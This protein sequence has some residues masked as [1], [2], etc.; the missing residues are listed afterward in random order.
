MTSIKNIKCTT[1]G[2]PLKV[3]ESE[4][5]QKCDHC[6]SEYVTVQEEDGTA[7]QLNQLSPSLDRAASEMAI[8]RLKEELLELDAQAIIKLEE[9]EN[10]KKQSISEI[11]KR[12]KEQLSSDAFAKLKNELDILQ[13]ERDNAEV[14]GK[15]RFGY[16]TALNTS[17]GLTGGCVTLIL[18]FISLTIL[19][20]FIIAFL[21]AFAN[22]VISAEQI[23]PFICWGSPIAAIIFMIGYAIFAFQ[24]QKKISQELLSRQNKIKEEIDEKQRTIAIKSEKYLNFI[25]EQAINQKYTVEE[26][27]EEAKTLISNE[28]S[29]RQEQL[30]K[31]YNKVK[32]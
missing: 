29:E 8:K 22:I 19:L 3:N 2:A 25:N 26:E 23:M 7:L 11:E 32:I 31:H 9:L 6:G 15:V 1:C 10:K 21:D 27:I 13:L 16:I 17:L 20:A 12:R 18:S 14:K 28:I 4:S 24:K 30:K 5:A